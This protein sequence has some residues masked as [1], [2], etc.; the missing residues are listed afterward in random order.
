MK[1]VTYGISF[2]FVII[3]FLVRC[4]NQHI[5]TFANPEI[6]KIDGIFY[7]RYLETMVT[8]FTKNVWASP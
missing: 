1:H 8:P 2:S 4:I 6:N 7:N 5:V 3:S